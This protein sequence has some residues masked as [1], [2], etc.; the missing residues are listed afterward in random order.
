MVY[1][2]I[3]HLIGFEPGSLGDQFWNNNSPTKKPTVA[4]V[5]ALFPKEWEKAELL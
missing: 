3:Y 2:C 4:A 5:P 1:I